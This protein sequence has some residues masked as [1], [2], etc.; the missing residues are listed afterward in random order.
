MSLC[1]P[2]NSA[3]QE[4]SIIIILTHI[5]SDLCSF[6]LWHPW[7]WTRQQNSH[8]DDLRLPRRLRVW[9]LLHTQLHLWLSA[10][11][12][13]LYHVRTWRQHVPSHRLLGLARP[14]QCA[15]CL[16]RWVVSPL[17]AKYCKHY[18]GCQLAP[19]TANRVRIWFW[20]YRPVVHLKF[21]MKTWTTDTFKLHYQNLNQCYI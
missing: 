5:R 18:A 16:Y 4:L 11:W 9:G 13:Q 15:P 14:Q 17:W 10:D 12:L 3:I 6:D 20:K 7:P 21:T 1:I 19:P 8:A 2:E